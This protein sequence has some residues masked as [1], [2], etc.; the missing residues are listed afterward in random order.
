MK[1]SMLPYYKDVLD[2]ISRA[3]RSVFRKEMRKAFQRLDADEREELK[4]WFRTA[5]LCRVTP[6]NKSGDELAA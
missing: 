4:Q 6:G 2:R 5:C 3:D 1:R